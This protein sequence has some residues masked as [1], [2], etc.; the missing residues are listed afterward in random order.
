MNNKY[1]A[2]SYTV[3][4]FDRYGSKVKDLPAESWT[5]AVNKGVAEVDP[6]KGSFAVLRCVF[7]SL[8]T[9]PTAVRNLESDEDQP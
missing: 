3:R 6:A 5:E 4:L 9:H 2:G 7:N 1:R 8:D